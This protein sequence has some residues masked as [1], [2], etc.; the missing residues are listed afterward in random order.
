MADTIVALGGKLLG[1]NKNDCGFPFSQYYKKTARE[2]D[3]Y[4]PDGLEPPLTHGAMACYYA[5]KTHHKDGQPYKK[6]MYAICWRSNT[7]F[8]NALMRNNVKDP[9]TFV[10]EAA[11]PNLKLT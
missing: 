1:T 4:V 8:V 5:I 7:S 6:P 11:T 3:E 9:G 10:I 2:N